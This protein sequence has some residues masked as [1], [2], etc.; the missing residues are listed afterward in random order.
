MSDPRPVP[1]EPDRAVET[2]HDGVS[3][4]AIG[5]PSGQV[6][7][8]P[9]NVAAR[10]TPEPAV[11]AGAVT[12]ATPLEATAVAGAV[13]APAAVSGAVAQETGQ[14]DAGPAEGAMPGRDPTATEAGAALPTYWLAS[15]EA[16]EAAR[17]GATSAPGLAGQ[18]DGHDLVPPGDS[19]A[20]ADAVPAG[21]AVTPGVPEDHVAGV[22]A[23]LV[24][25][26]PTAA[27]SLQRREH[28]GQGVRTMASRAAGGLLRLVV[29]LAL[30]AAAGYGLAFLV[31][32]IAVDQAVTGAAPSQVAVSPTGPATSAGATAAS[33]AGTGRPDSRAS[34]QPDSPSG[35]QAGAS[36]V[37]QIHVVAR[38]ETLAAIAALY[39]LTVQQIAAANGIAN[40]DLIYVGQRLVIPPR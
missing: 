22:E 14:P 32:R 12:P 6:A 39:G 1:P 23:P 36:A 38:G 17:T 8:Q 31:S 18:P 27:P 30:M 35:S 33:P 7:A 13:P 29:L 9:E 2:G 40:P 21:P 11:R 20:P 34:A 16:A 28:R 24:P 19:G 25:P 4:D 26:A 37:G 10:P 5:V 3:G 15:A